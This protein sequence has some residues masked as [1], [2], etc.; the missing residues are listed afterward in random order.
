MS[1]AI[2]HVLLALT[3]LGVLAVPAPAHADSAPACCTDE[4]A[5]YISQMETERRV[6]ERFAQHPLRPIAGC[7][8]SYAHRP[9]GEPVWTRYNEQGS[10]ASGGLQILDGTWRSWRVHVPEAPQYA[11][12]AHA[13]DWVQMEVGMKA[14]DREG[15][16]PWNASRYCWG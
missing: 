2:R 10:S 15:S 1:R 13:P 14:Y 12:A 8:S 4:Q 16:R 3:V 6:R 11:R 9:W 5:R 7:E